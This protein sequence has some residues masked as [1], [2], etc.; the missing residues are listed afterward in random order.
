[1]CSADHFWKTAEVGKLEFSRA[2]KVMRR[3]LAATRLNPSGPWT[4][5]RASTP[6]VR[7]IGDSATSTPDYEILSDANDQPTTT[8]SKQ[9]RSTASQSDEESPSITTRLPLS[10]LLD[11][12]LIA[13]RERHRKPKPAPSGELS[14]F[15]KKLQNNPFGTHPTA[16]IIQETNLST[17]PSSCNANPPMQIHR[18]KTTGVLPSQLR[19]A[20]PP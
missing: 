19:I 9:N 20:E 13:A 17:S 15:S 11:P 2:Q 7:C 3:C 6:T 16:Y 5:Y 4:L 8:A 1:M 14:P 12:K 18:P 10:P